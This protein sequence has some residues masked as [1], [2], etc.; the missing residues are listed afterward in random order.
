MKIKLT[1]TQQLALELDKLI[2]DL[3][4]V[5]S[6][7]CYTQRDREWQLARADELEAQISEVMY[8]MEAEC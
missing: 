6:M 3:W 4:N 5:Q 7:H 2:D 8:E 1:R